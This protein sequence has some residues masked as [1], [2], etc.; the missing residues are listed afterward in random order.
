M[1]HGIY[2]ANTRSRYRICMQA[3]FC[4]GFAVRCEVDVPMCIVVSAWFQR[5]SKLSG[6]T[7]AVFSFQMHRLTRSKLKSGGYEWKMNEPYE[8][9]SSTPAHSSSSGD[10]RIPPTIL[11]SSEWPLQTWLLDFRPRPLV[12]LGVHSETCERNFVG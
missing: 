10:I 9:E 6:Q 8:L 5:V 2:L 11:Y 4:Q 3:S 1:G 7:V 12:Q